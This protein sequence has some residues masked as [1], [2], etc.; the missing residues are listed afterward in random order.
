QDRNGDIRVD[1]NKSMAVYRQ[2]L[3]MTKPAP[4][5]NGLRRPLWLKR[6][7]KPH[8]SMFYLTEEK[9]EAPVEERARG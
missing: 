9:T 6:P 1:T 8:I 4:G 3:A 5:P 7:L 2:W